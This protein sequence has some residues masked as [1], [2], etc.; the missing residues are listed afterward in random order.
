M[1]G[2]NAG[3]LAGFARYADGLS[4]VAGWIAD[5]AGLQRLARLAAERENRGGPRERANVQP[6][7][8]T[9]AGVG[10]ALGAGAVAVCDRG[11]DD[12]GVLAPCRRDRHVKDPVLRGP[13]GV[14]ERTLG[15]G[16][17]L[18]HLAEHRHRRRQ[19]R[20]GE[21]HDRV[22][23]GVD[24]GSGR[25][26]QHDRAGGN[27]DHPVLLAFGAL[28]EGR[29]TSQQAAGDQSDKTQGC[30]CGFPHC[31]TSIGIDPTGR[32]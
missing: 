29:A 27:P 3:A 20:E 17:R 16:H 14:D 1:F 10:D 30:C 4:E 18:L 8:M 25:Q 23:Q 21:G 28:R 15:V 6:V 2:D 19:R 26:H 32:I 31:Q 9:V 12:A 24:G 11:H 13:C 22:G 7:E 5:E